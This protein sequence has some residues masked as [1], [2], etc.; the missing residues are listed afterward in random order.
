MALPGVA[1]DVDGP[2]GRGYGGGLSTRPLAG[3]GGPPEPTCDL[4]E[5]RIGA[6]EGGERCSSCRTGCPRQELETCLG[7][8][9]EQEKRSVCLFALRAR[10][11]C[12][13]PSPLQ[14][15][16]PAPYLPLRPR[17]A[18]LLRPRGP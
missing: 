12:H 8:W 4:A 3:A 14:G 6:R 7:C 18:S 5:Q 17:G 11:K 16:R 2:Q 10:C 13:G 1:A 15:G 9:R